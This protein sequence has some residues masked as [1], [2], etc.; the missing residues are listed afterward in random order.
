MEGKISKVEMD[1][2]VLQ[3]SMQDLHERER[4]AWTKKIDDLGKQFGENISVKEQELLDIE[5]SLYHIR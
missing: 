3:S 1:R 4:E 5:Q 2:L